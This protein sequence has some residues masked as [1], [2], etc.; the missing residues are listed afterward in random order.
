M[1]KVR[2]PEYLEYA[3]YYEPYIKLV[4]TDISVLDQLKKN[5]QK[6]ASTFL[7]TP[8]EQLLRPY[9]R[10]KWSLKDLLMHM[11]DTER[12]F[13]YRAMRF[14]RLDQTPLPF[15]DENNYAIV[16]KANELNTRKLVKEYT[17]TRQASLTF[18]NNLNA[19]QFKHTGMASQYNMSVRACAWII[20]GHELHHWSVM[21]DRYGLQVKQD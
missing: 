12:V 20:C 9:A 6:I 11:I 21:L 19:S 2:K 15:F 13:L 3:Q 1:K 16:A 4:Q 17:T 7:I 10:G 14:A 18:F 5:N 8:E